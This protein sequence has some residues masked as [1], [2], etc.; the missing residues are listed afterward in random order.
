MEEGVECERGD[1]GEEPLNRRVW[2]DRLVNDRVRGEA[3]RQDER[4][5]VKRKAEVRQG[6]GERCGPR[7][8]ERVR[9][10]VGRVGG[11]GTERSEETGRDSR[12]G[13]WGVM[14]RNG[15]RRQDGGSCARVGVCPRPLSS[16]C[17]DPLLPGFPHPLPT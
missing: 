11:R 1:P 16:A 6:K 8:G 10:R 4:G 15:V 17:H 9:G 5:G 7:R 13:G 12:W 2:R 3:R 14:E